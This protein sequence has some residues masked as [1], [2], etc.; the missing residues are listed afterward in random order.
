MSERD[1]YRRLYIA[2]EVEVW[3]FKPWA[4]W[5]IGSL[6]PLTHPMISDTSGRARQSGK[7]KGLFLPE[8]KSSLETHGYF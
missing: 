4:D 1:L 6:L 2:A 8:N 5:G 7:S 3:Y